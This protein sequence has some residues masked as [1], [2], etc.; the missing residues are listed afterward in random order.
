MEQKDFEKLLEGCNSGYGSTTLLWMLFLLLIFNANLFGSCGNCSM[1]TPPPSRKGKHFTSE[2]EAKHEVEHLLYADANGEA[3]QGE[4]W[5]L[6]KVLQLTKN[7]EFHENVTDL[8]K[9][10]A[11]NYMYAKLCCTLNIEQILKVTY[12]LFFG[13][14]TCTIGDYLSK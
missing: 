11:F 6:D 1:P 3:H 7:F 2:E 4:H 13:V 8:D 5:S 9:Y 12:T 14:F 10:V